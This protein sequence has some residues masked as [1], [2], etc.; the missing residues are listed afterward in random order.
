M[1]N[2][3]QRL[4]HGAVARRCALLT[5]A[6][7]MGIAV[8]HLIHGPGALSYELYIGVLELTLAAASVPLA[9]ALAIRPVR[10]LWIVS[11]ALAWLALGLYLASPS[12][13]LSSFTT[14]TGNWGQTLGITN[15]ATEVAA[16]AFAAWAL[17]HRHGEQL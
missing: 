6:G 11:S 7:F 5:A 9:I 17:R 16:I 1:T 2:A 12:I 13:G 10:D 15:M 3:L 14:G 8:V 4:D